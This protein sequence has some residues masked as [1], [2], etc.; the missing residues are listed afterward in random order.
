MPWSNRATRMLIMT[1]LSA[2]L[3]LGGLSLQSSRAIASAAD[4]YVMVKKQIDANGHVMSVPYAFIYG[5]TTYMPLWY[6]MQALTQVQ[7]PNAWSGQRWSITVNGQPNLGSAIGNG[8]IQVYVNGGLIYRVNRIATIDPASHQLTTFIPIYAIMQVLKAAGI[9]NGWDGTHWS[10]TY[11]PQSTLSGAVGPTGTSSPQQ[12]VSN[13]LGTQRQN[14]AASDQAYWKR[15]ASDLY[16]YAMSYDPSLDSQGTHPIM[17]AEPGQTI[18]LLAYSN[19]SD[20][21]QAQWDVN[22]PYGAVTA[23]S[24]NSSFSIGTHQATEYKFVAQ[25]PGIYTLQANANG[26]YSVPLVLTVGLDKLTGTPI[27]T[28]PNQSG[29]VPLPTNLPSEPWSAGAWPSAP[30]PTNAVTGAQDLAGAI[31]TVL[32]KEFPAQNGWI[33]VYGKVTTP[34]TKE[35][36]VDFSNDSGSQEQNYTLPVNSDGTFGALLEVPISGS[37]NVAFVSDFLKELSLQNMQG[38]YQN[39]YS[40]T[41]AASTLTQQAQ[42]LLASATMDY[43]LNPAMNQVA[44]VLMENSPSLDAGI[45]AVANYVGDKVKYDWPGYQAGDNTWQDSNLVWS[46]NSGVCQDIAELSASMLKS[47]GVPT[48][49]VVGTAPKGQQTDDHEWIRVWDGFSWITMDP[50]WNSPSSPQTTVNDTVTS[51]YMTLTDSFQSSHTAD[52]SKI[53]TWQ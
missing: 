43:N 5:G 32:Y 44:S 38:F 6:V 41:N 4:R 3:A 50:T 46:N 45:A 20:V 7:V 49:T 31:G 48:L 34:G 8:A 16:I 21:N 14:Q 28:T 24:S 22:S 17:T 15:S 19:K 12:N 13:L 39:V 42:G 27:S 2:V 53:G 11:G 23:V 26:E 35:M 37:V 1:N 40:L 51:E 47:V 33:P 29:I 10:M 9:P 18:Y 52:P 36:V 30:L 25:K